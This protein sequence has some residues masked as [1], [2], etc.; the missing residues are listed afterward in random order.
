MFIESVNTLNIRLCLDLQVSL[1]A[2]D[3]PVV[4]TVRAYQTGNVRGSGENHEMTELA[5]KV[6]SCKCGESRE[7]GQP[8]HGCGR[9]AGR[10]EF[11]YAKQDRQRE[12]ARFFS[13]L[14][15][16][17]ARGVYLKNGSTDSRT[18]ANS[19]RQAK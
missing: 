13:G 17:L 3:P 8:C 16:L 9:K 1:R 6:R 2:V 10:H 14:M 19:S 18:V 5:F 4:H 11:D 7:A 15:L 12:A